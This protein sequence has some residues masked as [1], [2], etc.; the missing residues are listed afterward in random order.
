[1]TETAITIW[2]FNEA[3]EHLQRLSTN[4]G[5]EDWVVIFPD[6]MT[7]DNMPWSIERAIDALQVCDTS[8]YSAPDG[9]LV[10]ITCHA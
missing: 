7:V 6:G 8:Y 5:D 3:P 4:G 9:R 1:M 10:A 2:P